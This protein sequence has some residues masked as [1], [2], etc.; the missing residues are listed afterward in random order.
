MQTIVPVHIHQVTP[1]LRA[2]F[3]V[4]QPMAIRC[5]ALLDGSIRGQIWTDDL[6]R[7]TWGAAREAAWDTLF[8]GG[9]PTAHV[10]NEIVE[11]L[12]HVK[13][14]ALAL[15]PD[16]PYNQLLPAAPDFDQMELEFTHRSPTTDLTPY[17]SVPEGCELQSIDATW[18]ARCRYRDV[19]LA[20]F[21]SAEQTL[22]QGFGFCLV[23]G[24]EILSEAFAGESAL[25]M[26]ELGTVTG[27]PYRQRGYATVV[28]AHL[29]LECDARGYQTYWNCAEDNPASATLAR[30][31]GH[32]TEK[33]FRYVGWESVHP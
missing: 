28:C 27:E 10:V 20:Y 33:K 23:Q 11:E 16:H 14:V 17:L 18:F 2:L 12:R 19:Y 1:Q 22:A 29:A 21:G 9:Q 3:D 13:G 8:L 4:N 6:D 32:Q 31:L 15:W 30:K 26:I 7:P 24:D 5:F 25:G